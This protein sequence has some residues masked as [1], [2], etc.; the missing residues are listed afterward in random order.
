MIRLLLFLC[1]FSYYT[2]QA[3]EKVVGV[4]GE[5]TRTDFDLKSYPKDPE[6]AAVVL[7]EKGKVS[8]KLNRQRYLVLYKEVHR[9]I[10]VLDA[11]KF[12]EDA[13]IDI[14]L[15]TPKKGKQVITKINA[16]SHLGALKNYV[17]SSNFYTK[18][19]YENYSEMSFTFPNV[20]DGSI[21]EYSYTVESPYFHKYEWDFQ[22]KYPKIYSEFI[23]EIPGNYIYRAHLGGLQEF[24]YKNS[25]IKNNCFSIDGYGD[26]AD[27]VYSEF[28]MKDIPAFKEEDFML[29]KKNYISRIQYDLQETISFTGEKTKYTKTWKDVDKEF[30]FDNEMGRQL[31]YASYFKD[32]LPANILSIA[33]TLERAKAIYYFIQ[34]NFTWNGEYEIY[35]NIDVKD[36]YEKKGGNIAEI[37]LML[38]NALD[39]ANIK[40]DLALS[41]TRNY[42]F[43]T[44]IYPTLTEYNYVM[45]F[46]KIDDQE[47]YLD[48]TNK[49]TPFGVLPFRALNKVARIMDFKNE[50]YWHPIN[51]VSKNFNYIN[52]KLS[53]DSQGILTGTIEENYQGYLTVT[54]R[55]AITTLSR[56]KYISQKENNF[57][58]IEISNFSVENLHDNEEAL[59]VTY[60]IEQQQ[61]FINNEIFLYPFF[62]AEYFKENPFKS[63]KRD[64]PIEMG[65]PFSQVLLLNI[66]LDKQYEVSHLPENKTIRLPG[67]EGV[68]SVVYLQN[69]NTITI[70]YKIDI[71]Q[72]SFESEYYLALQDFFSKV[73]EINTKTPIAL[74]KI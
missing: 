55:D 62:L 16:I 5:P 17:S 58:E 1:M 13:T 33:S 19:K 22:E 59:K 38:L 72:A 21:L 56:E 9:K 3:Q 50:S 30:R 23:S 6:A 20:Q 51:P 63:D 10:K 48:A 11:K 69:G 44:L 26:A 46:L 37:N 31:K 53:L 70:R 36:A 47:Y 68:L 8:V 28:V 14:L 40:A 4:F 74:K 42:G 57:S 32:K 41:A 29:A 49:F 67:N 15:Y 61:S 34:E 7:F 60:S 24:D 45:A 71:N 27:C 12:A 43:P 18:D 25:Y 54:E 2:L 39:A 73:V 35:E 65:Y 52:S 66:E 64:Y